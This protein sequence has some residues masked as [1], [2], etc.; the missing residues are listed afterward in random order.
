VGRYG[1]GREGTARAG[2]A[3]RST[4]VVGGGRPTP[5]VYPQDRARQGH[6]TE[7][8]R[9]GAGGLDDPADQYSARDDVAEEALVVAKVRIV[10]AGTLLDDIE[11]IHSRALSRFPIKVSLASCA[12]RS[13][14]HAVAPWRAADLG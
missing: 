14:T 6:H 8:G 5:A 4:R 12:S 10:V 9:V 13:S 2:A 7:R 11:H 1:L 3:A